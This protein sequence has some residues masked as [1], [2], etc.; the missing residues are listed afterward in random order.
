MSEQT[1]DYLNSMYEYERS[2][3]IESISLRR[4]RAYLLHVSQNARGFRHGPSPLAARRPKPVD[5]SFTN[6]IKTKV[7][8]LSRIQLS[9]CCAEDCSICMESHNKIDTVT[10][11]CG[12]EFGKKCYT[13]WL[14]A[15]HG[16]QCCPVC[17][18]QSPG[19]VSYRVR[20]TRKV[21]S[22]I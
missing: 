10:T 16:N 7:K 13:N 1:F 12:H 2:Q 22:L 17:R 4:A 3:N 15:P 9:A 18:K 21:S 11:S 19:L 8:S 20:A 14:R 5:K 6:P